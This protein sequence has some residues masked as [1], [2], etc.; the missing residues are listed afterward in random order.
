MSSWRL[1]RNPVQV[2]G[3]DVCA[4][5]S[6]TRREVQDYLVAASRGKCVVAQVKLVRIGVCA[7]VVSR[8]GGGLRHGPTSLF[9]GG[10]H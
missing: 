4:S 2:S 9:E 10:I 8:G 5:A 6:E 7:R 3:R 1:P